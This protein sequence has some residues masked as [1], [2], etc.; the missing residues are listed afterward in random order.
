MDK[1]TQTKNSNSP[2]ILILHGLTG[3]INQFGSLKEFLEDNDLSC[4]LPQLP[5]HGKNSAEA[6]NI[7]FHML[8]EELISHLLQMKESNSSSSAKIIIIGQS[9]GA[10]LA[11]HLAHL[12]PQDIKQIILLSPALKM[13]K[14][15]HNIFNKIISIIPFFI[16]KHLGILKKS[17]VTKKHQ[18]E[19]SGYPITFIKHLGKLQTLSKKQLPYL[20]VPI[21]VIQN[22]EDYHLSSEVPT[23]IKELAVNANTK[24]CRGNWGPQHSIAHISD[25]QKEI[26]TSCLSLANKH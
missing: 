10:L 1:N 17:L 3:T 21:T 26:L 22:N 14:K 12:F 23:L 11:I 15:F 4:V 20:K 13:G 5:G 25:V 8:E 2:Q 24:I 7:T 19:T 16:T 18:D 6:P 9:M